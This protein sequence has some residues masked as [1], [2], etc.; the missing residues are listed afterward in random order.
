MSEICALCSVCS[1]YVVAEFLLE[2]HSLEILVL[3]SPK[4]IPNIFRESIS[5]N[6]ADIT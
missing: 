6:I 3:L 2:V 1:P 5:E 4:S